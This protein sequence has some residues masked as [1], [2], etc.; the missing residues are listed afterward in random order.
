M[1]IIKELE[2]FPLIEEIVVK[3]EYEKLIKATV[4]NGKAPTQ[5]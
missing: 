4:L 5:T 2:G 3:L 1:M